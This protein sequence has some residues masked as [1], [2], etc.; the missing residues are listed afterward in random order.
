MKNTALLIIDV[1]NELVEAGPFNI[2][3]TLSNIQILTDVCR[4]NGIE[5]IYSQ[6]DE[7]EI[8]ELKIFSYG[9]EIHSSICPKP[10]EKVIWKN[11]NS[12]FKNTE[13]DEYLKSKEIQTLI[14]VGMQTE[15]CIDTTCRIA[16]EKG[17]KIIMPEETN[18]TFENGSLSGS[19]IYEHHNFRIFK[20]RFAEVKS[21]EEV[22]SDLRT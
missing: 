21:L 19:E 22:I 12:A 14:I 17:Y 7:D 4:E 1:Q 13:L 18:T 3:K 11:Y 8:E 5:V 9:W 20:N 15:Y 2:D 16:F 10:G 6:H